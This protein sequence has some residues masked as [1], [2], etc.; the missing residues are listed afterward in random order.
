MG[1]TQPPVKWV[2]GSFHGGRNCLLKQVIE[3]KIKEEMQV[4]RTRGRRR[5]TLLDALKDKRG[6]SHLKEDAVCGGIVLEEALDLSS[7]RIR[8]E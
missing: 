8:N 1:P 7:D 3:G 4:T 2:T 6:Y 5:K